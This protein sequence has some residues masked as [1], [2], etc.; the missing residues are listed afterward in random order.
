MVGRRDRAAQRGPRP[1]EAAMIITSSRIKTSSG[2]KA[3][4]NHV[5]RGR[6]NE[7]IITLSGGE[8]R[9]ENA[10]EDAKR[11]GRAYGIRHFTINPAESI[12]RE[13][14]AE[15]L[16]N[17]ADEFQF[18]PSAATVIEHQK[19]RA[20]GQAHD[21]HW[22][23]LLPEVNPITGSVMT[24]SHTY[25][26]QEKVARI[27]EIQFG[28]TVTPGR[29]NRAVVQALR[30]EGRLEIAE[31]LEL[32]GI[33]QAPLPQSAFTAEQHQE[34]K[35]KG[36][37]IPA[38]K[39]VVKDA[40]QRSDSAKALSAALAEHGLT[41]S[42]GDKKDT[43]I[44]TDD[45]GRFLGA[46][47][48]LAGV[49]KGQVSQRMQEAPTHE[50]S[51]FPQ[52][53]RQPGPARSLPADLQRSESRPRRYES[54]PRLAGGSS[55]ERRA[56]PDPRAHGSAH[57][58][59]AKVDSDREADHPDRKEARDRQQ[60]II[61][62]AR[63]R[64]RIRQHPER[65]KSPPPPKKRTIRA[66]GGFYH[67]LAGQQIRSEKQ[68]HGLA[69][70]WQQLG[71]DAV[72]DAQSPRSVVVQ[73]DG[74]QL[75]DF[76][77]LV[78]LST[79]D[80]RAIE[81]MVTKARREWGGTIECRGSPQFLEASW[82][83]CQRQGVEFSVKGN[84]DWEPPEH[85]RMAWDLEQQEAQYQREQLVPQDEVDYTYTTAEEPA[86]FGL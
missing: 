58:D 68:A 9:L 17:L 39:A 19:P 66:E 13:Q 81:V 32:A 84:P 31:K 74:W 23:V 60:R 24:S 54:N 42:Q 33:M 80:D 59:R 7:R 86:R 56:R 46:L 71:F 21:R 61:A 4:A 35:R 57:E 44:L 3:V 64:S 28:H 62:A 1:E 78:T 51:S 79:I 65:L 70:R 30:Q 43:W 49:R 77:N 22:H 36:L 40:W 27:A 52:P 29:H 10:I 25:A 26:R 45:E 20:D 12:S 73:G 37:D 76:G 14:A 85:I 67:P 82:L 63:L 69:W 38:A 16:K 72:L 6:D 34:A 47:H 55:R 50:N 48:R 2:H 5:L 18:D 53:K 11:W 83:E 15:V 41:I 75:R 8:Y